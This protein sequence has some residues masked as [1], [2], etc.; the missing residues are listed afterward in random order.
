MQYLHV[1]E[2][3]LGEFNRLAEIYIHDSVPIAQWP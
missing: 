1:S 2:D 3:Q